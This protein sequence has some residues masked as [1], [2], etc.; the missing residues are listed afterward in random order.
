VVRHLAHRVAVMY[1]GR[2]VELGPAD[3]VFDRP[4]HPYTQA[5]LRAAPKLQPGGR[6]RDAAISGELPSP[7]AIPA[8]CPFHPRCPHAMDICR[9]V[10]PARVALADAHLAWCHLA[11]A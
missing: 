11:T 7:L 6:D 3:A 1:L 9:T 10:P 5:L 8:G 2:V 4:A